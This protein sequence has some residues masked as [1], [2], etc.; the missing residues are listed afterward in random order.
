MNP[1]PVCLQQILNL[2]PPLQPF[3]FLSF[4]KDAAVSQLEAPLMEPLVPSDPGS[5]GSDVWLHAGVRPE[6]LKGGSHFPP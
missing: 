4:M 5:A 6:S 2:P 1:D 3:G